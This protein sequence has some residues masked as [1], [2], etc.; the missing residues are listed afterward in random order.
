MHEKMHIQSCT[1]KEFSRDENVEL[2]SPIKKYLI[3]SK[4]QKKK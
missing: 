2:D 4:K 3:A 1:T